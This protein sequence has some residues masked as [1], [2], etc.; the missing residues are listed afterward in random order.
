MLNHNDKAAIDQ[1]RKY[2]SSND[3]DRVR[4]AVA[5]YYTGAGKINE[6]YVLAEIGK[7]KDEKRRVEML[8]E[9]Y[10]FLGVKRFVDGNKQGAAEYFTRSIETNAVDCDEYYGSK[11][12]LKRGQGPK[13]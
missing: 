9:G 4:L 13:K 6:Q 10:F 7:V 2:A 8:C 3:T 11:A 1:L 5:A 12:M